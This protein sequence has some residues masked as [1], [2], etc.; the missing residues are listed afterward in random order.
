MLG[1]ALAVTG[2]CLLSSP[3]TVEDGGSP[4]LLIH[5]ERV[6]VKPGVELERHDILVQDGVIVAVGEGL[7]APDG[8]RELFGKV[9]CAG[10]LDAWSSLGLEAGSA[11]DE[12]TS[13]STRSADAVDRY[14]SPHHLG[15]ALRN[16]VTSARVQAGGRASAGGFG[17]MLRLDPSLDSEQAVVLD[18]TN[19]AVTVGTPRGGRLRD[20][21]DRVGEVSQVVGKIES[22]RKYAE[23][24]TEY[25]F[26]LEEWRKAVAEKEEELEKDF[27]KA[28]KD[29]D[30][31]IKEAKEKD[32]EFKEERYKEDKKPRR[33]K[34]DPD[35]AA[36]ARV[37]N[38]RCRW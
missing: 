21:F 35:D 15:D 8:T 7:V 26:E 3:L 32:K 23:S 17:A 14:T 4:S 22:G 28:K 30:K 9:V 25:G 34:S 11:N 19:Q 33:P 24:W 31:E 38:G 27:K 37:A 1:A 16:G 10:F 29:R 36:M 13:A 2:L 12:G 20:I 6:I 18:D 5:A